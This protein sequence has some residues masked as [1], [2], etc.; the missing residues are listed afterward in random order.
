MTPLD[1][2]RREDAE[3]LVGRA[4]AADLVTWLQDHGAKSA[5]ELR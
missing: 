4:D 3:R 1:V 5:D 2:A